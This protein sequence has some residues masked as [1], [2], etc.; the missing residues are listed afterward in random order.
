MWQ[1]YHRHNGQ[2]R[3][4]DI[5]VTGPAVND[6]PASDALIERIAH[7][8]L[9]HLSVSDTL[10]TWADR[11]LNE[12]GVEH[13]EREAF[14]LSAYARALRDVAE[15]LRSGDMLPGMVAA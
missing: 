10:L 14:F 3:H 4:M 8:Y 1:H 12:A 13:D 7:E 2:G 15:H 5:N 6:T 9:L 11:C